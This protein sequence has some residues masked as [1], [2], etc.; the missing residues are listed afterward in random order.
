MRFLPLIVLIALAQF[1]SA[2]SSTAFAEITSVE[3][4]L[5][6]GF[7]PVAENSILSLS[8]NV[9]DAFTIKASVTAGGENANLTVVPVMDEVAYPALIS[10]VV[11][12]GNLTITG[13]QQIPIM[14]PGLH[15]VVLEVYLNNQLVD[16]FKFSVFAKLIRLTLEIPEAKVA[17]GLKAPALI[18][19]K[20]VNK[21]NEVLYSLKVK[22][23]SP[24]VIKFTKVAPEEIS[25]LAPGETANVSLFASAGS[26]VLI[27]KYPFNVTVT[28]KD[29]FNKTWTVQKSCLCEVT[30][31]PTSIQLS[32]PAEVKT[33]EKVSLSAYL[34][35]ENSNPV[36]Q[37]PVLFYINDKFV[38]SN[39]TDAA[40]RA[41]LIHEFTDPGDYTITVRFSGDDFYLPSTASFKLKATPRSLLETPLFRSLALFAVIFGVVAGAIAA[42]LRIKLPS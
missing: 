5:G 16:K 21:G 20:L 42:I 31:M 29:S 32:I 37:R 33:K 19:V 7:I 25:S 26:Q 18:P 27:G 41:V 1:A 17:R 24:M 4:N 22:A 10:A 38:G 23:Y 39:T 2:S 15:E 36:P 13:H 3:V 12:R 40:G 11:T 8:L 14:T 35:D 9:T 34:L 28:F 6:Q 30:L